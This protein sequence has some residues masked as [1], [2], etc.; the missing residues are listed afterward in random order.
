MPAAW[1]PSV[2]AASTM[3]TASGVRTSEGSTAE[4]RRS[5]RLLVIPCSAAS[6]CTLLAPR[7]PARRGSELQQRNY[8]A[9]AFAHPRESPHFPGLFCEELSRKHR[10][11][12]VSA[13]DTERVP[14]HRQPHR[15]APMSAVQRRLG[16]GGVAVRHPPR[17]QVL[18][19]IRL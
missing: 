18:S 19:P 10:D 5:S 15:A 11:P 4:D 2:A 14:A 8:S 1:R 12:P 17:P 7:S 9:H 6:T 3:P 16:F 13:S